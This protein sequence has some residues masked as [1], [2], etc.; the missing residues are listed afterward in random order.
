MIGGG[1]VLGAQSVGR[2][3]LE[4]PAQVATATALGLCATFLVVI[5]LAGRRG[6]LTTVVVVLLSLGL[7][8]GAGTTRSVDGWWG[9]VQ[10]GSATHDMSWVPTELRGGEEY[11]VAAGD[12]VLDLTH[13]DPEQVSGRSITTDVGLGDLVVR[14]PQGL[15][16]R[17]RGD[18]GLGD[19]RV[20][21][22]GGEVTA[23]GSGE[24]VIG[25]G[26]PVLDLV[27]HVGLGETTIEE[28]TR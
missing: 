17:V 16:V 28:V 26:R 27:A 6:G 13:L 7:T 8:A 14:V 10:L 19:L 4:H 1:G 3:H 20:R 23:V 12:G 5:G 18:V 9:G 11:H 21:R 15:T 22:A 2:V 24:T 25:R